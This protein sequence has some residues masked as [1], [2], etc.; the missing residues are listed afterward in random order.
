M[1]F[2]EV[3]QLYQHFKGS[4][5]FM[6]LPIDFPRFLNNNDSWIF[7]YPYASQLPWREEGFEVY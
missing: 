6:M 2:M 5:M 7:Y 3:H 4:P 1:K